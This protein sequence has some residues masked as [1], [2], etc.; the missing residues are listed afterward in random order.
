MVQLFWLSVST[1]SALSTVPKIKQMAL[2]VFVP[3]RVL[4]LP[5]TK[6]CGIPKQKE[7]RLFYGSSTDFS[8][9]VKTK[10][11]A[12]HRDLLTQR[13]SRKLLLTRM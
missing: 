12:L 1:T 6:G 4:P 5:A 11:S 13:A 10:D 9:Q 3:G 2:P 8:S 7:P